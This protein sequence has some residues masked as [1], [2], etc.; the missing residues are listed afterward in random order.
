MGELQEQCH[1]K[2]SNERGGALVVSL[3]VAT[4]LLAAGGALIQITSMSS[5]NAI[6]AT[7]ETQAY[8]AAEAGLQAA[9]NALRG[10]TPPTSTNM[11]SGMSKINFRNAVVRGR[12]NDCPNGIGGD[13]STVARLSRWLAYSDRRASGTR[14]NLG[15]GSAYD[16]VVSLPSPDTL[17][18]SPL[19][20]KRLLVQST[21][22]GPNNAR[23]QISVI[24]SRD[25]MPAMMTLI[26]A[27]GGSP[28]MSFE[29]GN[30]QKHYSG[31]DFTTGLPSGL[32]A[33][34]VTNAP[35]AA[36]ATAQAAES[37]TTA[38]A[39]G[40]LSTSSIP[41]YLRSPAAT[42]A[43][44]DSMK[45]A[46]I[47]GAAQSPAT[48]TYL[49]TG[50]SGTP[51]GFTFVNGDYTMGPVSGSGLLIVTGEL[52]T[53]GATFF[54]GVIMVLGAGT[55]NRSGGGGGIFYGATLIANVDWPAA[56]PAR[57]DF[58]APYFDFSGGGNATMQYD[59]AAIAR[60]FQ[61]LP[62]P[63]VMGV[64]EY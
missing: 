46:A 29:S 25:G 23:K 16:I 27:P 19:E 41:S 33:F 22:Y 7:A 45:E 21:G 31:D 60:A 49:P 4:A 57:T 6:D 20:P 35:D 1:I 3:I 59:S 2:R 8:Y 54:E 5:A 53:S 44:L 10:N 56:S 64:K 30:D 47:T 55:V 14:V 43:F 63:I 26:G 15:G 52:T 12:S 17:P 13:P 48:A 32:P 40:V 28:A 62:V 42:R 61:Y 50:G 37:T 39:V 38:P 58:G 36:I 34:A 11:P 9:L 18:A 51:T 24:I